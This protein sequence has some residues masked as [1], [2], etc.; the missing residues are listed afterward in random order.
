MLLTPASGQKLPAGRKSVSF[1]TLVLFCVLSFLIR[2]FG[3]ISRYK[4]P[5]TNCPLENKTRFIGT[6]PDDDTDV[7]LP[8]HTSVFVI[9]SESWKLGIIVWDE[10]TSAE[11]K[12]AGESGNVPEN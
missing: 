5:L 3:E 11:R 1:N 2:P 12:F 10:R 8:V 9:A 6:V 4:E 7:S